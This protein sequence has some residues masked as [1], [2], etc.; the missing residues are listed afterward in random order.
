MS[1]LVLFA[2]AAI[3]FAANASSLRPEQKSQYLD[4]W[5]P[6]QYAAVTDLDAAELLPKK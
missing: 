2:K 1:M 4:V 3:S 5:L 6:C